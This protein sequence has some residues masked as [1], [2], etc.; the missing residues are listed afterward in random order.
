MSDTSPPKAYECSICL[1][2]LEQKGGKI[3]PVVINSLKK[4]TVES[5]NIFLSKW[6]MWS[7]GKRMAAVLH[8]FTTRECDIYIYIY[9]W[10][11]ESKRM[12]G[13]P[14]QDA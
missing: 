11:V 9:I 8:H 3:C 2:P 5:K 14:H 6:K 13:I 10:K 4:P 7:L 1:S 12:A